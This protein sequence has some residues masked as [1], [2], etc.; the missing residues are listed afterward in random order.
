M[1]ST[2]TIPI[3]GVKQ[4]IGPFPFTVRKVTIQNRCS[5]GNVFAI[6]DKG[7]TYEATPLT[8]VESKAA[9]TV[10]LTVYIDTPQ[11]VGAASIIVS[12]EEPVLDISTSQLSTQA[13]A[14]SVQNITPTALASFPPANPADG[15]LCVLELPTAYDPVTSQKIRWLLSYNA[16]ASMWEAIGPAAPLYAE[17]TTQETTT[18]GTYADLPTVGPTI[19]LPRP[20]DYQIEHG[21]DAGINITGHP[22]VMSY[23]LLGAGASDNDAAGT[24]AGISVPANSIMRRRLKSGILTAGTAVAKYRTDTNVGTFLQRWITATP[25]RLT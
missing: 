22:A 16:A 12:D 11:T 14:S 23:S 4:A 10:Y 8:A 13:Q 20:G 2:W 15:D 25:V 21:A 19:S 7:Q 17:I 3:T 9:D 5:A 1:D 24:T 6:D 18:S